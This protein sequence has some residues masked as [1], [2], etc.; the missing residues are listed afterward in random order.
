VCDDDDDD[1]HDDDV[2]CVAGDGCVPLFI[3]GLLLHAC[4]DD[5]GEE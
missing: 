4:D 3:I 2:E 1:E 5:I